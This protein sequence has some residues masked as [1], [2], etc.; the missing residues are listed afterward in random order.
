[1]HQ[2]LAHISVRTQVA[3]NR[4]RKVH[5]WRHTKEP[6]RVKSHMRAR[7][8]VVHGNLRD[9]MNLHDIIESIRDFG[10]SNVFVVVALFRAQIIYH[11]IWKDTLR[12]RHYEWKIVKILISNIERSKVSRWLALGWDFY[13]ID[14]CYRVNVVNV[15][16]QIINI[17]S[18]SYCL[19]LRKRLGI[20]GIEE[21]LEW[22]IEIIT[23]SSKLCFVCGGLLCFTPCIFSWEGVT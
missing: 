17:L 3:R 16:S 4:T 2:F 14:I 22:K 5:I 12:I 1:M 10:H 6:I 11:Y 21:T 13:V 23:I 9:Q 7:G 19:A 15:I 8:K 20:I 18:Q